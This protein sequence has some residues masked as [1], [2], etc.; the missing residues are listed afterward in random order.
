MARLPC[1]CPVGVPQHLIQW[2]NN[3]QACLGNDKD[4]SAYAYWHDEYAQK[5]SVDIHA[6]VFMTN[7]ASPSGDASKR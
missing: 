5:F 3:R 2:G 7:H 4:F 6:W 1:F